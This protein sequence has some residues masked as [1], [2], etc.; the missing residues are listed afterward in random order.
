MSIFQ[1]NFERYLRDPNVLP[2]FAE[3]LTNQNIE[4]EERKMEV[5]E[6]SMETART[7]QKSN[8][9]LM[10]AL[11][12]ADEE[13]KERLAK[14]LQPLVD[15]LKACRGDGLM[16]QVPSERFRFDRNL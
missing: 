7:I 2:S 11:E 6:K 15:F 12:S 10:D 16:S 9:V 3:T 13:A 8:E 5:Y 14:E 1:E 4:Q